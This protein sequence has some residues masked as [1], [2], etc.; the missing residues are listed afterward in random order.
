VD[1]PVE[2]FVIRPLS[3]TADVSDIYSS[4]GFV[5]GTLTNKM[6]DKKIPHNIMAAD[7]G[8]TIYLI[9]RRHEQLPRES[10]MRC[11]WLEIGGLAICRSKEDFDA[12]TGASFAGILKKD[13][14]V[15]ATTFKG[16]KDDI[17]SM[18]KKQY[19]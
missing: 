14:S 12:L 9:P 10:S 8:K 15:D 13:V 17:V 19:V 1:Y 7:F 16:L 11:A 18:L 4:L 2:G 5:V 3:D 6:L